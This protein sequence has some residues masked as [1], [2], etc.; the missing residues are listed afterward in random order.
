MK[1][2]WLM[3]ALLLD[4]GAKEWIVEGSQHINAEHFSKKD[5]T[6]IRART[7]ERSVGS[8]SCYYR[9]GI[10][11]KQTCYRQT[12]NIFVT[13]GKKSKVD[14]AHFAKQHRLT[15][16]RLVNP[17]YQTALFHVDADQ[18]ELIEFVNTLNKEEGNIRA[19]VEWISPRKIR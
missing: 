7:A 1:I 19:R 18:G 5:V 8:P 10:V 17:L 3:G 11:S 12:G 16:I 2:L 9:N 14:F 4:V 6:T 13:F 15:F